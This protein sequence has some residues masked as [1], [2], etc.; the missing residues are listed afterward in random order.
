MGC[1]CSPRLTGPL[2]GCGC[3]CGLEGQRLPAL[4]LR[5]SSRTNYSTIS[6]LLAVL[7]EAS[8]K[9]SRQ[10]KPTDYDGSTATPFVLGS[11]FV[12]PVAAADPDPV[13]D[14]SPRD[15]S[16]FL[17]ALGYDDMNVEVISSA[18]NFCSKEKYYPS[19]VNLNYHSL[20][21]T[22]L[23]NEI[24]VITQRVANV[25]IPRSVYVVSYQAPPGVKMKISPIIQYYDNS[26]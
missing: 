25:G 5:G 17:C 4:K 8:S 26:K 2:L 23:T 6:A 22:N 19:A 3:S 9:N 1:H 20:S 11:G 14:E 21:V 10:H 18:K 13:Y 15:Y 7:P 16:L 12:N 24:T